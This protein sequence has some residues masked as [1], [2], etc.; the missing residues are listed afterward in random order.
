M[1]F[2]WIKPLLLCLLLL[3]VF[4]D[5]SQAT[6]LSTIPRKRNYEENYYYVIEVIDDSFVTPHDVEKLLDVQHEGQVGALENWHVF[7]IRK[8]L[9]ARSDSEDSHDR[10]LARYE[11]LKSLRRSD[12]SNQKRSMLQIDAIRSVEKQYLRKRH[13]RAPP[14]IPTPK[15]DYNPSTVAASLGIADPG[16]QY[17]WHLINPVEHNDINVTGITG[18]GVYAAIVDDG[19]DANSDDLAA[20]FFAE[21]SYDFNDHVKVPLP[22]LSDDTHGTRCAGEIAA[23]KND[24]CGVGVA[25]D[26][27]IAGIRILSGQISDV[28]EAEAL[29]YAF[30]KNQIYSCSWGPPDDGQSTEAPKGVILQAMIKGIKEGRGGKG[31]IFV[32]ASGNGGAVD[33]NCNFDGYTNSIYTITVGAVD[34]THSHPYYAE[35]CSAL[36]ISTYSSGSGSYIFTTDVGKRNCTSMHGGTSAAAPIATGVFSLVLQIRPDLTWRD[37][38]YLT[39]ISAVPFNLNEK[40]WIRNYAGRLYSHKW[41]Y[42]KLDAY[43]IVQNAKTFKNLGTQVYLEMPVID[44]DEIIPFSDHGIISRI[45]VTQKDIDNVSLAHLEHVTVTINIEHTRRGDIEV[46]LISPYGTVSHLGATR[47]YDEFKGGLNNWTFMSVIHWDESPIGEWV[48]Q[49][50][51][52]QNPEN[53]GTFKNWMLKLWGGKI[54]DASSIIAAPS[55]SPSINESPIPIDESTQTSVLPT[56]PTQSSI[57]FESKSNTWIFAV[58]GMGMAFIFAGIAYF[59]KKRCWDNRGRKGGFFSRDTYESLQSGEVTNGGDVSLPLNKQFI[60]SRELF[61]AFGDSSDDDESTQVVF[62][63]AYMDEYMNDDEK[64]VDNG[65][66]TEGMIEHRDGGSTSGSNNEDHQ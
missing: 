54:A 49:V 48:I 58:F 5:L 12:S 37:L 19:L 59:A 42:G 27:K 53:S 1:A 35:K 31:S 29:N 8:N 32:F 24:V 65:S 44:V 47:R 52:R 45:N 14:P 22:R 9:V 50:R 33:D 66:Y 46:D 10:V 7:S 38:Q 23:A 13:K 18:K 57:A 17:Q 3:L 6:S 43:R 55:P 64:K 51:D 36:L 39:M 11:Q 28:D 30:Q 60:T 26:A 61:D 16:F 15:I 56:V 34:R 20:N 2:I 41:G 21:G 62:E 4:F 40:E 25:P 63:N